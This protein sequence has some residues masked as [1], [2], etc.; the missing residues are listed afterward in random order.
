[1]FWPVAMDFKCE[2]VEL[3]PDESIDLCLF[4]GAIRTSE[5][6]HVAELMRRKSKTLVAFGSCAHEGCIPALANLTTREGIFEPLDVAT[7]SG[8]R[9]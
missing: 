3:M 8:I 6:A 9:G 1:M 7:R 2:D 5:N 4:N